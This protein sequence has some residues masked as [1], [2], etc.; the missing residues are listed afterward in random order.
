MPLLCR[1]SFATFATLFIN[2]MKQF[3]LLIFAF[4]LLGSAL[5]FSSC[6]DDPEPE[7]DLIGTW[8]VDA[9]EADIS[10]SVNDANGSGTITF[11]SDN[12]GSRDYT[13]STLGNT[14]DIVDTFTWDDSTS[15]ELTITN[16]NGGVETWTRSIDTPTAQEMTVNLNISGILN[17][18]K[19]NLSK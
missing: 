6:G 4:V 1:R 8:T 18:L 3:K 5:S 7:D 11:N 13:F 14:L 2:K 16:N 19:F 12:S 9:V 10:G 17:T 15:G